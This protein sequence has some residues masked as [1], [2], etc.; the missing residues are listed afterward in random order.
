LSFDPGLKYSGLQ[1]GDLDVTTCFG[2]DG[3]IAAMGLRVLV[4][5]AGFWPP[6]NVAPVIR[7]SVIDSDPRVAVILNM[8]MQKLDGPTMSGLN[9]EVDGNEQ[10]PEDVAY[11]F[12]VE[13]GLI[14]M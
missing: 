7:T 9:W 1:E 10:Q 11:N 3:Q 4:D 14:G 12:L 5:D 2:T 8:L 13:A 6:Y